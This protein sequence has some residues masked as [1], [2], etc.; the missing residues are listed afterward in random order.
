M[1]NRNGFEAKVLTHLEYIKEKLEEHTNQ[2]ETLGNKFE[3]HK[4]PCDD[5]FNQLKSRVDSA[6]GWAKGAM[7]VGGFGLFSNILR[8]LKP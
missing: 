8:W 1:A 3:A 5:R 4:I 7:A 2:I 6:E